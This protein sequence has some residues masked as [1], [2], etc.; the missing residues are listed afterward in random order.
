MSKLNLVDLAGS[1]RQ[2]KTGATGS[3][4]REA[5]EINRSLLALGNVIAALG[6][7]SKHVPYRDSVLTRLLQESLGGNASTV[8]IAN[9]GPAACNYEETRATFKGVNW[10][11]SNKKRG[12]RWPLCP[13]RKLAL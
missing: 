11:Q 5:S 10:A 8:M 3:G 2:K 4:L 1:E 6:S 12:C 13:V 7:G 9:C